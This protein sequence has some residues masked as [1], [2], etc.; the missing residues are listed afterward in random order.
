M[1]HL[2]DILPDLHHLRKK[3]PVSMCD[4]LESSPKLTRC[5]FYRASLQ[6]SQ[7]CVTYKAALSL[8]IHK[9]YLQSHSS[10]SS[11]QG[12]GWTGDV[13][14]GSSKAQH[15]TA[16]FHRWVTGVIREASLTCT[17]ETELEAVQI[18]HLKLAEWVVQPI[19]ESL[20][21]EA[22]QL[23]FTIKQWASFSERSRLR[24]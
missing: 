3:A 11:D 17:D 8:G 16:L 21:M 5:C 2:Q 12:K 13:M 7:S 15:G 1:Q 4:S 9:K 24:K 10:P 23:W 6:L 14:E 22:T 19:D 20:W 18:T